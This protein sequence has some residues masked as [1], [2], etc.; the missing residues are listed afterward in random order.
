MALDVN[1]LALLKSMNGGSELSPYEQ[2]KL[3][4]LTAKSHTGGVAV[5][6]LVTGVVGVTAGVTAW[7]FGGLF[8]NAKGKEAKE[9]AIAAK[10]IAAL[11][12]GATQRQLDQL[13]SLFAAERAER[14]NGDQTIT[15]TVTDTVSGSQQSSLTAQ[16]AAELSAVNSVMTQTYSDFVTGRASLNPTPVSLYSAPQPCNCPG[17]GCGQ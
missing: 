5:A 1:D 8:A 12:N 9:V 11:Q 14:I 4:H 13:T 16:Q 17:C 2:V 3:D 15:Q 10:E 7:L 6:G